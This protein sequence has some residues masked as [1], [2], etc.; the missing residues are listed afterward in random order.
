MPP[1]LDRT[2]VLRKE[3]LD[4]AES[5]ATYDIVEAAVRLR[6]LREL[7]DTLTSDRLLELVATL[8][9]RGSSLLN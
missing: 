5:V 7:G 9:V 8:V 2:E 6:A 4:L 1:R 3:L